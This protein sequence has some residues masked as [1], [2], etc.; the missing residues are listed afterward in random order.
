MISFLIAL[1]LSCAQDSQ[2]FLQD[3]PYLVA[4]ECGTCESNQHELDSWC[5]RNC[6]QDYSDSI[7]IACISY[8]AC[9]GTAERHYREARRAIATFYTDCMQQGG[10]ASGCAATRDA[11]QKAISDELQSEMAI[12]LNNYT[13][14]IRDADQK[15]Y[16]CMQNCC[17]GCK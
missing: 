4:P 11:M 12:C 17:R 14:A 15:W 1:L 7:A 9:K 2:C 6:S 3:G 16:N 5:A 8:E 10:S 13:E